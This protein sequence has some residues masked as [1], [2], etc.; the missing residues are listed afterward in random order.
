MNERYKQ[1]A[2]RLAY[3]FFPGDFQQMDHESDTMDQACE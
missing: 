3:F 1:L 2:K